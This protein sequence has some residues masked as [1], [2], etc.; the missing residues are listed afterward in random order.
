VLPKQEFISWVET[1]KSTYAINEDI[2][3]DPKEIKL[4]KNII[5]GDKS[6]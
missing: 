2:I 3:I 1:A 4:T 5:K 6:L